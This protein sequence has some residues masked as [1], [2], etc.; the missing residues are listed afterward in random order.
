MT[1]MAHRVVTLHDG[2]VQS[3]VTNDERRGVAE[4]RW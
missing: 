1:A 2:L 4:I 3:V